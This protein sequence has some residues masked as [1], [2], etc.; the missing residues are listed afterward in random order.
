MTETPPLHP[1]ERAQR[2]QAA[3]LVVTVATTG[4]WE[5]TVDDIRTLEAGGDLERP[6]TVSF[7]SYETLL[8]TLTPRTLDLMEYVRRHEP[9][10]INETARGVDRDVKNVHEELTRLT[11]VGIIYFDEEG[12]GNRPVVWFDELVISL[13][14]GTGEDEARTVVSGPE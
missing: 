14:V 1:L 9:A 7:E 10:S 6:P 5:D 12:R 13:P 4:E 8:K 11:Q 2:E 3:T